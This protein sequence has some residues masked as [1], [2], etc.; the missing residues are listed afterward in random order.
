MLA[1][2][3]FGRLGYTILN[4]N[5]RSG[6]FEMDLILSKNGALHFVEVKTRMSAAFGDPERAIDQ[7]KQ[8]NIVRAARSFVTRAG[9]DWNRV[10]FDT[11]SV[12]LTNPPS[13]VHQI[14][15]FFH[16]RAN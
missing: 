1:A 4:R 5:W 13:I 15:A 6:R 16:G 10:R 7:E 2:Q 14:D 9:I 3:Y 12:L 8:K 11:I